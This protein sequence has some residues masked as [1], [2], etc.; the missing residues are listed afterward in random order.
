M[1]GAWSVEASQGREISYVGSQCRV[2]DPPLPQ[3]VF[4][5]FDTEYDDLYT[6]CRAYPSHGGIILSLMTLAGSIGL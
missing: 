3:Q 4:P 6:V 2:A 1:S 5:S